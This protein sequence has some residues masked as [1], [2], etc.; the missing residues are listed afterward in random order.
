M[1]VFNAAPYVVRAI[2]SALTQ[3]C[4]VC[5]VE[6]IVVDD[7]STDDSL[8]LIR[9][10]AE[11]DARVRVFEQPNHGVSSARNRGMAAARGELFALLDSDDEWMSDYLATHMDVLRRHPHVSVVTSNVVE[12]GGAAD[13]QPYWPA[14]NTV[15]P[16]TLLDL[17]QQEDS[18]C[19]MSVFRREVFEAIGGFDETLVRGS[20]DYDFWLRTAAAGFRLV[21]QRR[22]FGFYQRRPDSMSAS[23]LNMLESI[24]RV[25]GRVKHVDGLSEAEHAAIDRQLVRFEQQHLK[26]E[27]VQALR[28]RHFVTA[29]D[30]FKALHRAQ[31]GM[32]L[33]VI[34][35]WSRY[36]PASLMRIDALRRRSNDSLWG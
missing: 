28:S 2:N 4:T 24:R 6:V 34:A 15:R 29:A 8:S 11:S 36:A 30:R 22:P 1:P 13:G 33:A 26:C 25:L 5:D 3:S 12:R 16:L 23:Q 20:E 32:R 14:S 35:A 27:A 9:S 7:G 17:I 21:Q 18:V 10:L 19:I 31:G